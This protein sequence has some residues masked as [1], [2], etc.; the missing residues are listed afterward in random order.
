MLKISVNERMRNVDTVNVSV[1]EYSLCNIQKKKK[2]KKNLIYCCT[3][4]SVRACSHHVKAGTKAKKIEE[5]SK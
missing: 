3:Y 5:Q 4:Q 2:K 1:N